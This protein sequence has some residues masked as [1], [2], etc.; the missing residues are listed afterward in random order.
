MYKVK[1]EVR[2]NGNGYKFET[3]ENESVMYLKCK[4]G[5]KLRLRLGSYKLLLR[6]EEAP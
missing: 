5:E 1:V 4:I 3:S 6:D 2:H